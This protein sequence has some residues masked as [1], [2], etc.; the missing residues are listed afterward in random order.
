MTTTIAPAVREALTAAIDFAREQGYELPRV[1]A[2]GREL[3]D[4]STDALQA[5]AKTGQ[6]FVRSGELVRVVVDENGAAKLQTINEAALRGILARAADFVVKREKREH[7]QVVSEHDAPT[8]PPMEIVRDILNLGEWELPPIEGVISSPIMRADGTILVQA[9]YDAATRLFYQPAPNFVLPAIPDHPDR[10]AIE[11]AREKLLDVLADFPFDCDASRDNAIAAM[12]TIAARQMIQGAVPA[13]ACD[14]PQQSTGKTLLTSVIVEIAAGE[15]PEMS[16]APS[17][18]EEWRKTITAKLSNGRSAIIFD[19]L[20]GRLEDA[21][22]AAVLTSATWSDRVLGTQRTISLPARC[23]F[24]VTGNNIRVGGDL[25]SR[26]I[27]IRI[28]AQTSRPQEREGFR[29]PDL[30]DY[31]RKHRAELLAALL[32]LCRAWVAAGKPETTCPK[33]RYGAWR[34]VVGGILQ[35][36]GFTSFLG[37]LRQ[38]WEQ[39]DD[40][41]PVW[42][43]FIGKLASIWPGGQGATPGQIYG[44]LVASEELAETLPDDL[45]DKLGDA[46]DE[47]M[48]GK[49][50]QALGYEFKSRRGKRY[51]DSQARIEKGNS[52]NWRFVVE[53]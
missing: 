26:V 2:N 32:T 21:S 37:N 40:D 28:D 31:I 29:H 12:V 45:R 33:M 23:V 27:P 10:T 15:N 18:A 19:N 51:G 47:R 41:T 46:T 30:A 1:Q 17:E 36:A 4:V 25:V 43:A 42:E 52:R 39:S 34:R 22:L 11:A 24:F 7:G 9:G 38:F 6:I 53:A 8:P 13:I 49:F 48:K 44:R 35:H 50:T 5:L 16:P 3:R 14:S 20:I